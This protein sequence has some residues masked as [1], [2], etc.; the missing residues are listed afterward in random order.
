MSFLETCTCSFGNGDLDIK[1]ICGSLQFGASYF[2][3]Y[4]LEVHHKFILVQDD[5]YYIK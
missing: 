3:G 5:S 1:M 4:C 2:Q